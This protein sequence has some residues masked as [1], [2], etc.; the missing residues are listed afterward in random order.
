M[1]GVPISWGEA[2]KAICRAHIAGIRTQIPGKVVRYDDTTQR[3]DVEVSVRDF[4]FTEEDPGVP[5]YEDMPILQNVPVRWPRAGDW[6]LSFPLSPGDR[7][8]IEFA[9]RSLSEWKANG[10]TA[11]PRDLAR[12][13]E[14]ATCSVGGYPEDEPLASGDAAARSAGVV[15]GKAGTN[16]QIRIG[17]TE[18]KIG[19]AASDFVAL[20]SLVETELNKIKTALST[21][22]APSGGGP[23]TYG[24][25]YVSVG[26]VGASLTKAQ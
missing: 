21:A 12:H 22:A 17:T 3:A 18:I 7:V 15:I 11:S 16:F 4:Y 5:Q 24:T 13:A 1:A 20:K 25:P 8:W 23:V 19:A 2:I 9:E 10:D 6:F 26:S 14:W